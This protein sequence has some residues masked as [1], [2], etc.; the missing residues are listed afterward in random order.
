ML[1]S[2]VAAS[3]IAN[4]VADTISISGNRVYH[5]LND[6][7][8]ESDAELLSAAL[9]EALSEEAELK[10][11]QQDELSV[12]LL[13]PVDDFSLEGVY[14][15]RSEIESQIAIRLATSD[16]VVYPD[17]KREA[18][19][20]VSEAMDVA[21]SVWFDEIQGTETAQRYLLEI[22]K[23]VDAKLDG[24]QR[25]LDCVIE[26]QASQE[27]YER[28]DVEDTKEA[29]AMVESEL[30]TG[31]PVTED[32]HIQRAELPET[33]DHDQY[34]IQG[35]RGIGKTHALKTLQQRILEQRDVEHVILPKSGYIGKKDVRGLSQESFSGHVLL[36]WD[37]IHGVQPGEQGGTV[38][39]AIQ[40]LSRNISAEESE[41]YLLCSVGA[42]Y[43][44][45]L[46]YLARPDDRVWSAI[47]EL[48]LEPLP[49]A[50]VSELCDQML[51]A[52][53]VDVDE[54][55]ASKIAYE[56]WYADPSPSYV[57]AV[58]AT[59]NSSDDIE[60]QVENLPVDVSGIWHEQYEHLC[61]ENP[62]A[63]FLLWGMDLLRMAAIPIYEST[64]RQVYSEV[65]GR[66]EFEFTRQLKVLERNQW[67]WE[68]RNPNPPVDE[69]QYD[70]RA[71]QLQG[72]DED[73]MQVIDRFS[74]FVLESL[75][76]TIPDA[77]RDWIPQYHSN[78]AGFLMYN[79]IGDT[80]KLAEAHL[81]RA[82]E[83]APFDPRI[84][85]NFALFLE[86]EGRQEEALEHYEKALAVAPEWAT[87]RN[88]YAA[89]LD[90]VDR[91]YEAVQEYRKAIQSDQPS[92][93][94]H[95]NLG[96]LLS[97]LKE[98]TEAKVQ[99]EKAR[100]KG[101]HVPDLYYNLAV[102]NKSIGNYLEAKE[103]AERGRELFPENHH[104]KLIL[105]NLYLELEYPDRTRDMLR[106]LIDTNQEIQPIVHGLLARA[107]A[108]LG[109][110]EL[111][112][113][114]AKE[115]GENTSTNLLGDDFVENS[116]VEDI[117]SRPDLE[118]KSNELRALDAMAREERYTKVWERGTHFLEQGSESSELHRRLGDCGEK[119]NHYEQAETHYQKAV[120]LDAE[121]HKARH[122]YG[123][124]LKHRG[125]IEEAKAQFQAAIEG[126]DDPQIYNDYGLLNFENVA[127]GAA[128]KC[129]E[130][131]IKS[132]DG[133]TDMNSEAHRIHFNYG[134][135]L[136][137]T[138][139]LE[140]AKR[141]YLKSIQLNDEYA[142]AK[143]GLGQVEGETGNVRAGLKYLR[144]AK[145]LHVKN[146]NI[147]NWKTTV[148]QILK[149]LKDDGQ[150]E[151]GIRV[152]ENSIEMMENLAPLSHP[153]TIILHQ[154]LDSFARSRSATE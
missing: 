64:L 30:L 13:Q 12:D 125:R 3:L 133:S 11:E 55:L 24:I 83:L 104:V 48:T 99:F 127:Y 114:H 34:L 134:Q 19:T 45:E 49:R 15:S 103:I 23:N 10:P 71:A 74:D 25:K 52:Y 46:D 135:L 26:T 8:S 33:L 88:A 113:K 130:A 124:F 93:M 57:E 6:L 27:W 120:Q 72:V 68:E 39:E 136:Y 4:G 63:R 17:E 149:I 44:D 144:E 138:G 70:I 98:F 111:M 18:E 14:Q 42:E 150:Y 38:R 73:R 97:E 142:N 102:V 66:D 91:P 121:N 152:C 85:N 131:A 53:G 145:E 139:A 110:R 41:L 58:V 67:V 78:L 21:L 105:A 32:V 101:Y 43:K 128:A 116:T 154:E 132:L 61:R 146:G 47:Q 69:P 79:L 37:D 36:I 51:S 147:E 140:T 87:L 60:N 96:A 56:V 16:S 5:T 151:E 82:E 22:N 108:D 89:T 81:E 40:R 119:L 122:H 28:I 143:F 84:Q 92:V 75:V 100:T 35:R 129:Y 80:R 1:E 141:H 86:L 31:P 115:V 112:E 50:G 62:E 20:V 126:T 106:P 118:S 148:R 9:V 7:I 94:A 90:E 123:N 109:E 65:F 107:F 2:A 77:A 95:Y 137:Y 117:R 29:A 76:S 59:L 153:F 54:E